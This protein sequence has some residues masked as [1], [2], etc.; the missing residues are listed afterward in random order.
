MMGSTPLPLTTSRI[1][2]DAPPGLMR[3]TNDLYD[4]DLFHR[5]SIGQDSQRKPTTSQRKALHL[6]PFPWKRP[7]SFQ[8]SSSVHLEQCLRV[9]L[10]H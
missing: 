4:L 7:S 1:A 9:E 5:V 6:L 10:L 3:R 8:A 2:S